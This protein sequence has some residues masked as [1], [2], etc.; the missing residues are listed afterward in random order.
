MK[1]GMFNWTWVRGKLAIRLKRPS[2]D[3][4]AAPPARARVAPAPERCPKCNG[5]V[6]KPPTESG[7]GCGGVYLL[8]RCGKRRPGRLR[9]GGFR[10]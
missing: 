6:V 1:P 10:F 4:E 8:V 9:F 2:V 3:Q 5:L 7:D